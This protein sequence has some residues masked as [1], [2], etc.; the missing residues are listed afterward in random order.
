MHLSQHH[1]QPTISNHIT[2]RNR[3]KGVRIGLEGENLSYGSMLISFLFVASPPCI[4][5]SSTVKWK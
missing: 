4:P 3:T 1:T 2:T 5:I